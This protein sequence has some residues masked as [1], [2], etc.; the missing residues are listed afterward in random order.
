[1]IINFRF[2]LCKDIRGACFGTIGEKSGR[3]ARSF[4]FYE[5]YS[6]EEVTFP[7]R[8]EIFRSY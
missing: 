3:Y 5:G 1:M 6:M 7:A 8:D 2:L 4:S